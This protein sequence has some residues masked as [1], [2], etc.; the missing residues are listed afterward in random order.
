MLLIAKDL[1]QILM[2]LQL[3]D[4]PGLATPATL[5]FVV[6]KKTYSIY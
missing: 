1:L 5:P 4:I 3:S 6:I 2:V